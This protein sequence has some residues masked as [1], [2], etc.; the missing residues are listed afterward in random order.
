MVK[1]ILLIL[2]SFY[3]QNKSYFGKEYLLLEIISKVRQC[4]K[5]VVNKA[6]NESKKVSL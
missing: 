5:M 3:Q 2:N 4:Y 6:G 1:I